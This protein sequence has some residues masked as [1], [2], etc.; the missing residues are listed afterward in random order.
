M[1]HSTTTANTATFNNASIMVTPTR[2]A[3]RQLD[4]SPVRK[5]PGIGDFVLQAGRHSIAK[6]RPSKRQKAAASN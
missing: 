4:L 5:I 6:K 3:P 2:I 1:M